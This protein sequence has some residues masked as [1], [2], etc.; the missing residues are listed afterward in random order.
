MIYSSDEIRRLLLERGFATARRL[1]PACGQNL[2][3]CQ[4]ILKG[5]GTFYEETLVAFTKFLR[6]LESQPKG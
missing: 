2:R 1:A 3:T 4:K 6:N 5:G